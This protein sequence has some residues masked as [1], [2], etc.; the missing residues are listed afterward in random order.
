MKDKTKLV[1]VI[2]PMH[3]AEKYILETI[4]SVQ[5]QTYENWEMIIIDNCST[6]NSKAIV[7]DIDDDRIKLIELEYNSG[8]P[9]RPRNLGIKHA[10][11][12]YVAFLDADDVLLSEKLTIQLEYM[13]ENK[14]NFT[15]TNSINIDKDSRNIDKKY[16]LWSYLKKI[17]SKSTLCDLIKGNF[18]ATSS[19]VV[20][21]SVV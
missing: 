10:K 9:A 1:S 18:I 13:I 4:Q 21:K 5:S 17:K 8:G 19:V 14:Y 6:D 16:R 15:S 12:E 20:S 3:N 7:R 11:G 2:T